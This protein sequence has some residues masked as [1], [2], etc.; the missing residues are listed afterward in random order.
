MWPLGQSRAWFLERCLHAF[1]NG[2]PHTARCA[3]SGTCT[4]SAGGAA[5]RSRVDLECRRASWISIPGM[6]DTTEVVT[7]EAALLPRPGRRGVAVLLVV[8]NAGQGGG[9]LGGERVIPFDDSIEIGRAPGG[10]SKVCCLDDLRVSGRQTKVT[11]ERKDGFRVTDLNSRN[12]TLV[13]GHPV[14]GSAQVADGALLSV[15][16]HALVVRLLTPEALVAIREDLASPLGPV[17]SLSATMA[18][19]IRRLRGMAGTEELIL[20][21]GETGVGKEVYARAIHGASRRQ[22]EFVAVNCSGVDSRELEH[23]LFGP[24]QSGR[25][26]LVGRKRSLV[27]QA[28]DGTLFLDKIDEMPAPAQA[29][30]L[31]FLDERRCGPLSSRKTR[32]ATARVIGGMSSM[33]GG[34]CGDGLRRDLFGRFCAEPVVLPPLRQRREDLG[35]LAQHFLGPGMGLQ[36]GALLALCLHD[37]PQN[38]RELE[39]VLHEAVRLAGNKSEIRLEDLPERLQRRVVA[40]GA[41]DGCRPRRERPAKAELE[42]LLERHGGN[43]A[44]VARALDRR[45]EVV[46][47]WAVR[48]GIDVDRFRK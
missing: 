20:L 34:P 6:A 18:M 37:W 43:L 38:V 45:W 27:A 11:R 32:P 42:A 30:L 14:S 13:D 19:Q 35:L 2:H 28:Q 12:G 44:A 26:Q 10:G 41:D 22:G 31:R 16:G 36:S 25:G 24:A 3:R 23:A 7:Q 29:R 33:V 9:L 46:W 40:C 21:S 17:P 48:D 4:C 1:P 8:G 39:K 5:R 15:G 47:R